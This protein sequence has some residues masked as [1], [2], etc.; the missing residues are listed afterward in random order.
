VTFNASDGTFISDFAASYS[1]L[2]Y[3]SP[4]SGPANISSTISFSQ[5]LP[6]G[7]KLIAVDVDYMGENLSLS[8]SGSPLSLLEQRETIN[9]ANSVFPT[10]NASTGVL[11]EVAPNQNANEASVFDVSGLSVIDVH[12]AGGNTSSGI[13]VAIALPIGS[14]GV[15][16]AGIRPPSLRA[17]PN[18]FRGSVRID[19][20]LLRSG[21]VWLEIVDL[22]GRSIATLADGLESAG[23]HAVT[24]NARDRMGREV[25]T[26]V[27]FA[28]LACEERMTFRRLVRIEP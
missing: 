10:Y 7:A 11:S 28:R 4:A 13:G 27:Y 9:G 5:A 23:A 12:R 14:V 17:A 24:W 22:A 25:R 21:R 15:G 3:A 1:A 20:V 2:H 26:G 16:D 8:S 6:I 19:Y 18:P